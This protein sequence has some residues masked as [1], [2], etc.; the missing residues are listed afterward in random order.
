MRLRNY[1]QDKESEKNAEE[2]GRVR[3]NLDAVNDAEE[4]PATD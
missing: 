3:D 2:K 1:E 4:A